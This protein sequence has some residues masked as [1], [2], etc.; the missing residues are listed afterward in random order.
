MAT[1]YGRWR[2]NTHEALNYYSLPDIFSVYYRLYDQDGALDLKGAV[3]KS[4]PTLGRI[5]VASITPPRTVKFIKHRIAKVEGLA[6]HDHFTVLLD[7][8]KNDS[9][10]EDD[11]KIDFE[12][13]W[14]LVANAESPL[15]LIIPSS[16]NGG[17]TKPKTVDSMFFLSCCYDNQQQS[18][19]R[20]VLALVSGEWRV[21]AAGS[22]TRCTGSYTFTMNGPNKFEGHG[23][24]TD[25]SSTGGSKTYAV[26][27][28]NG[29]ITNDTKIWWVCE[30]LDIAGKWQVDAVLASDGKTMTGPGS[31]V[32][33]NVISTHGTY[34]RIK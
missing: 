3:N 26:R 18:H 11:Q 32:W 30:R 28:F 34:T 17:T 21:N 5:T 19:R 31:P 1:D 27:I 15:G 6:D 9:P 20:P 16:G 12:G 23:S 2:F 33:G 8:N 25:T 13:D 29:K 24:Q 7:L 14:N 10:L 22:G 4:D